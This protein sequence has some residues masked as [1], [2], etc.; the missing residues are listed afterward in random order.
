MNQL[1]SILVGVD[2]S[3]CSKT[4]LHQA[5]RMAALNHA[6]LHVLHVIEDLVVSE[7]TEMLHISEVELREL[8]LGRATATLEQ[9]LKETGCPDTTFAEARIGTPLDV[10]LVKSRAVDADLI[11]LGEVG[12]SQPGRGAGVLATKVLRKSSCKVMLVNESHRQPFHLVLACVDFSETAQQVVVQALRVARQDQSQLHFLHVIDPPW[13]RLHYLHP[14]TEAS[15]DFQTQYR[16][17]LRH[18]L[19]EFVGNVGGLNVRY[20]LHEASSFGTGIADY[21]RLLHADLIV[22]GTKGKTNLKYVL[23]GS[24]AERLLRD[25][26][27]SVLA[28]KPPGFVGVGTV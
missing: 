2:F 3:D 19:E 15:P 6:Q 7:F 12:S 10:I 18:H 13:R 22:L 26:P 25:V 8:T 9:W 24:T 17:T 1:K 4:A 11:V 5:A 14:T 16:D 28:I 21:A 20:D 27:C 23:L